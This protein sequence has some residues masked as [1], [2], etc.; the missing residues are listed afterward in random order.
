MRSAAVYLASEALLPTGWS[1]T[2]RQLLLAR[3][4]LPDDLRAAALEALPPPAAWRLHDIG[5]HLGFAAI[6]DDET[7]RR[8]VDVQR[9]L[10]E[11]LPTVDASQRA[12]HEV[13]IALVAMRLGDSDA[14]LQRLEG[15]EF[16]ALDPWYSVVRQ[17]SRCLAYVAR[18]EREPARAALAAMQSAFALC[19]TPPPAHLLHEAVERVNRLR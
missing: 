13:V 2:A 9:Y 4:G 16:E 1:P 14:A 18:D 19:E 15:A 6:S 5:L 8:L 3:P 7:R 11:A 10:L 12:P 17:F